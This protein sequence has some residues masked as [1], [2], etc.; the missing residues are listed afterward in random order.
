MQM[1]GHVTSSY[2]SN[3]NADRLLLRN[4]REWLGQTVYVRCLMAIEVEIA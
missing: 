4:G 2:W 1:I 3:C